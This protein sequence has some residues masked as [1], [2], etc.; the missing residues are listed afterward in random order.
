MAFPGTTDRQRDGVLEIQVREP[1]PVLVPGNAHRPCESQAIICG[2]NHG[3]HPAGILARSGWLYLFPLACR[4][5][6]QLDASVPTRSS[7][8]QP[9]RAESDR[10]HVT[11]EVYDLLSPLASLCLPDP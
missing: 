7:H 4:L 1:D 11:F 8:V 2:K 10:S 9:V 3:A 6:E 5:L